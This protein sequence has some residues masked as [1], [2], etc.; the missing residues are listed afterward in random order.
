M[1]TKLP[2]AARELLAACVAISLVAGMRTKEVHAD[3]L[4]QFQVLA[5]LGDAEALL[6]PGTSIYVG[7]ADGSGM[8]RLTTSTEE[9]F[10]R[11][12]A[13]SHDG[14]WIAYDTWHPPRNAAPVERQICI[15]PSTGGKPRILGAGAKPSF[16]PRGKRIAF[17]GV[18]SNR[19][20][21]VMSSE[22]PEQELVQVDER[23]TSSRW[24]PDGRKLAYSVNQNGKANLMVLD[25]IEGDRTMLFDLETTPYSEVQENFTWSPDS[26]RIAFLATRVDGKKE[27]AFVDARGTQFGHQQF[28]EERMVRG[29]LSFTPD[30]NRLTGYLWDRIGIRFQLYTMDL[31]GDGPPQLLAKQNRGRSNF[32]AAYSPDGERLAV[33]SGNNSFIMR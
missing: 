25:L 15:V 12:P 4:Q 27:L 29:S 32:E 30:G 17:S 1:S 5:D 33:S 2:S 6:E 23:G 26:R 20:V 14:Q 18:G 16:S 22:G 7:N 31:L 9:E 21:W 24:S 19:G 10:E 8:R 13:W 11:A 3:D 28:S